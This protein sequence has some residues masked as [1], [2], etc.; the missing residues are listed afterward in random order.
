MRGVVFEKQSFPLTSQPKLNI[1][2]VRLIQSFIGLYSLL[3]IRIMFSLFGFVCIRISHY[4]NIS[5][6]NTDG[7]WNLAPVGDHA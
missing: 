3:F 4:L 7:L 1:F 2:I 6:P 5:L